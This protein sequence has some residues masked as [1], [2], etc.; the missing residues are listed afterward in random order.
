MSLAF[1]FHARMLFFSI[2]L[3]PAG[4]KFVLM[5]QYIYRARNTISRYVG[6][7]LSRPEMGVV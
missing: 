2:A 3:S 4:R 5:M 6:A 7:S 1:P